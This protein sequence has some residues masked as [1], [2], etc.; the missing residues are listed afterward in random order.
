[1]FVFISEEQRL[2]GGLGSERSGQNEK[3]SKQITEL[4]PPT[5]QLYREDVNC[6]WQEF[7]YHRCILVKNDGVMSDNLNET[8]QQLRLF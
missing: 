3:I 4:T 2:V 7:L 5:P 8:K 6:L 1:M